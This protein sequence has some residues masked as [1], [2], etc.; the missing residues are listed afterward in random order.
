MGTL[1]GFPLIA[2]KSVLW[3]TLFIALINEAIIGI[4]IIEKG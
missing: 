1:F 3:G 4:Y 2:D